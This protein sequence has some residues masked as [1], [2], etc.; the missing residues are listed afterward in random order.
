MDRRALSALVALVALVAT[1]VPAGAQGDTPPVTPDGLRA[2]SIVP[3]GQEGDVTPQELAS[4][5]FGENYDDQLEMYASLIDDDDVTEEELGTYFHSMQFG[6]GQTITATYEPGE[7]STVFRDG[8][9]IPHIYADS[10]DNAAF[11]LGYVTAE[12]RLWEADVLRHAAR[13]TLSEFIGPDYLEMDVVTRR[14]GYTEEEIQKMF[15]DLDD[16]FG[17]IGT[18][19]QNGLTAYAEGF[20]AYIG[21]L[22][23][24]PQTCPAEYSALN[25]PCPGPFP[26][27]W[28][29]ADTLF[30]VVLQLRVFGETAGG[31]LNNAALYSHLVKKHG[32]KLGPKV[33]EDMLFQNDSRSPTSIPRS[34]G[35]FPS[36]KLGKVKKKSLAIPDAAEEV[37]AP[38][39]C[40]RAPTARVPGISGV[41]RSRLECTA[42]VGQRIGDRQSA[43]DWC[44]PGGLCRPVLLHG[45]RRARAG[46]GFPGPGGT[47]GIRSHPAW[48]RARLRV[49]AHD[50]L[51]GCRRRTRGVAV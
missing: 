21:E 11:A 28:T 45:H 20:N 49:V 9:G 40:S 36:Q 14:D 48:P 51:L 43:S 6:P 16:K 38:G 24:A 15:D 19:V 37:A 5:N 44:A 3:P 34:E 42:R 23:T 31:E 32:A 22:P 27:E 10:A 4:G 1:A 2:Y 18:A 29:P 30:L 46:H 12:D 41:P 25:N 8:H 35:R 50:R 7:G 39:G 47:G 33:F 26:T 13:G 17:E